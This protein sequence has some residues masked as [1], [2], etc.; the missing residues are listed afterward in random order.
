MAKGAFRIAIEDFMATNPASNWV[1]DWMKRVKARHDEYKA[2]LD[3]LQLQMKFLPGIVIF[4]L[5]M[6]G[7]FYMLFGWEIFKFELNAVPSMKD[8]GDFS[9]LIAGALHQAFENPVVGEITEIMGAAVT[10][11]VLTLFEQY[12]GRDD[13]DPKEFA[14]AFHGFMITLNTAGGL[15]D[16]ILETLTAG[17]VEGVGRLLQSVY[18]SLGL[19]FLGWQTLAPLLSSGLQ[20][21]LDRYYRKLYRPMRFSAS[22][23]RDLYALGEITRGTLTEEAKMAGWRDQDVDLWIKLAFRSLSQGDI[24]DAVHQGFMTEEEGTNRLR[25]LGYDPADIPL[26]FKLNPPKDTTTARDFSAS[27]ARTA[28][29]DNLLPEADLR[30]IL[31]DLNY[32]KAEIDLIV[33]I[34]KL[35]IQ[36]T[37][38]GLSVSQIKAA[39]AD[40]VLTETEAIH[41]L[42]LAGLG[43]EEIGILLRSWKAEADPPYRKLNAGTITAA[44]T[45]AVLDRTKAAAKLGEIGF[46]TADASLMLDL[47]EARDPEA[48]GKPARKAERLLTAGTLVTFFIQGILTEAELRDRLKTAGYQDADIEL[49]AKS[50]ILD[51][52][53]SPQILGAS[54]IARAYVTAVYTRDQA[55]GALLALD[56]TEADAET[57]LT[58]IEKENLD[59]FHPELVKAVRAPSVSA[60]IAALQNGILSEI[61]FAARMEEIGYTPSDV[62]LYLDLATLQPL[63]A[64]RSLTASQLGSAYK[65]GLLSRGITKQRIQASGYNEGDTEILLK[66]EKADIPNTD[67]WTALLSGQL[68]PVDT[69]S[70]LVSKK[71]TLADI[72]DAFNNIPFELVTALGMN[73]PAVLAYIDELIGGSNA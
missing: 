48:F 30:R 44:Y 62:K 57:L 45:E 46:T 18:W 10:E 9:E 11:P 54:T 71:Y 42:D 1:R 20:P 26:I 12:A 60:L 70:A 47:A 24:F 35:G 25:A 7:G 21:G 40:N 55:K 72:R 67:E 3:A 61:D 34:E 22:E 64:T 2:T 5:Q 56:Y 33:E 49:Y 65:T 32:P 58:V 41:W 63:K 17:Q 39:W 14:R 50:A 31:S 43:S 52:V 29:R 66:L 16:T 28:F 38:K 23:L 37:D 19:G 69:I 73:V 53:Q 8:A 15:A 59:V 4:S 27:T 51:K 68:N 36:Q 6:N 13:V